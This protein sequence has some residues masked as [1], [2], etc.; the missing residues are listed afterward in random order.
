MISGDNKESFGDKKFEQGEPGKVTVDDNKQVVEAKEPLKDLNDQTTSDTLGMGDYRDTTPLVDDVKS[1]H[2]TETEEKFNKENVNIHKPDDSDAII[3]DVSKPDPMSQL[4]DEKEIASADDVDK[5]PN[6]KIDPATLASEETATSE[7][8]TDDQEKTYDQDLFD[9]P[10]EKLNPE[11][12]LNKTKLHRY[13][14]RKELPYQILNQREEEKDPQTLEATL[15]EYTALD[16]LDENNKFICK[17][18]VESK[19]LLT[20][21]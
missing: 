11:V 2:D 3:S 5:Q 18:C 6:V 15:S 4:Q 14:K 10:I 8:K 7:E 9:F 20:Y 21:G 17:T 13:L 1:D 19:L 12:A 16:V